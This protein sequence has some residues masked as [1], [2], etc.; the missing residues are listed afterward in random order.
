VNF[1]IAG[2]SNANIRLPIHKPRGIEADASIELALA[3]VSIS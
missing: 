2:I 1:I 3:S